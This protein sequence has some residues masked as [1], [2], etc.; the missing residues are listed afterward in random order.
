MKP[1]LYN[2]KYKDSIPKDAVYIGRGKG[3]ALFARNYKGAIYG[4]G[5][6]D[7]LCPMLYL[8]KMTVNTLM[9]YL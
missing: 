1:R 2:L 6:V 7:K 3:A 9:Y 5:K 4:Q 8:P